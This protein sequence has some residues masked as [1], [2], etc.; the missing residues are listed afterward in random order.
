MQHSWQ[1]CKENL[2]PNGSTNEDGYVG[3][4]AHNGDEHGVECIGRVVG[5]LKHL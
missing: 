2:F 5:R 1:S 3:R 4:G